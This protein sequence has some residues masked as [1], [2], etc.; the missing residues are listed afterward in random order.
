MNEIFQTRSRLLTDV[1]M[2]S[3]GTLT[4]MILALQERAGVET[5]FEKKIKEMMTPKMEVS[6]GVAT[7]PVD[8][9][10]MHK[11]SAFEMYFFGAHN[12]GTIADMANDAATDPKIKAVVLNIDSGGGMLTGTPEAADALARLAKVKPLV[13][14]TDSLMASAAYWVG[15]QATAIVSTKSAHVGSIGVFINFADYSRLLENLGIKVEVIKNKGGTLKAMGAM[16]TSLS[17]EQRQFLQD[18][19]DRSFKTFSSEVQKRRGK[20]EASTMR[21]QT[22]SGDE[23]KKVNLVDRIG[24]MTFARS[25]AKQLARRG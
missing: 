5:P 1:P 13:T 21:G 20:L 4:A 7:I 15:C 19:V 10:M 2:L 14:F 18:Q 24:D 9:I 6:D 12:T 8:G 11:P 16:G 17:D 22:L 3:S 23:A 25:L